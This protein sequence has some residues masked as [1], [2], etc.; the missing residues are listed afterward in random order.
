M[1][2]TIWLYV[3]SLYFGTIAT[4]KDVDKHYFSFSKDYAG[5]KTINSYYD[6][7]SEFR[8]L[9]EGHYGR[10]VLSKPI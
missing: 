8:C 5:R 6:S 1:T 4:H 3:H 9:N 2:M 7:N 10:Q